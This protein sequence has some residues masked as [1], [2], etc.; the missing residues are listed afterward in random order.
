MRSVRSIRCSITGFSSTVFV[1]FV[2]VLAML[3]VSFLSK[4][5]LKS[6]LSDVEAVM[7]E[8]LFGVF[9]VTIG[10]S[11]CGVG[12][13]GLVPILTGGGTVPCCRTGVL[14]IGVN[15]PFGRAGVAVI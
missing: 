14:F 5:L 4:K 2:T 7:S 3:L 8:P 15:E 12:L 10:V 9:V 6:I 11:A 1:A 13:Y